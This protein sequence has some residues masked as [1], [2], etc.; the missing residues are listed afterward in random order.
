MDKTLVEKVYYGIKQKIYDRKY[1]HSDF[2]IEQAVAN[3]F[4]VSKGTAAEALHRL[5]KEGH[6]IS[7]PRKGYMLAL[8]SPEEF[9][10]IQQLRTAIESFSIELICARGCHDELREMIR[11]IENDELAGT[12]MSQNYWFHITLAGLSGNKFIVN[13]LTSLFDSMARTELFFS[14]APLCMTPEYHLAVLNAILAGDIEE[15]K[16]QLIIDLTQ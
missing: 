1:N 9:D 6:L 7:Y 14:K 15:A 13:T 11:V 4:D 3:E 10:M 8:L 2:L 5:C 12:D 16:K